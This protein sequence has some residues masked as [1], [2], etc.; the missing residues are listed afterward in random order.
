VFVRP[1]EYLAAGSVEE[2]S[3]LLREYSGEAKVLAGGQSLMPMINLGLAQPDA[4]ID[5]SGIPG[6]EGRLELPPFV[7][8]A[9]RLGALTRHRALELDE[10]VRRQQPLISQAI[11]HVGNPRVR[12]LGTLGGSLAHNDPAA[13]LPLVMAVLEARYELSDGRETRELSAAEFSLTYFTT[14]L[15]DDELL[16]SVVVPVLS[17]GWGYGFHEL[18]NRAGD[19]AIV[20]A[21]AIARWRNGAIE[22]VRL[23]LAGVADRALRC[24]TYEQA[25]AGASLDDLGRLAAAVEADIDPADD[26]LVSASYRRTL[27]R[28]LAT[29]AVRD[30]CRQSQGD[31]S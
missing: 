10:S 11:R 23:G 29:R 31:R 1:F 27:A 24:R 13:E 5:I 8:G 15:R 2:A 6:L 4:V 20:A 9:L 25:A 18:A 22:T 14:A 21:A 30:A 26:G 28:V 3:A 7:E 19:F 12:N 17:D 16:V